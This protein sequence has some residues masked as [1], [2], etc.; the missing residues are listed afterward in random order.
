MTD[1]EKRHKRKDLQLKLSTT[2]QQSGCTTWKSS[3]LVFDYLV[4]W[5]RIEASYDAIG[6]FADNDD[7]CS[8][9]LLTSVVNC[10]SRASFVSTDF[11]KQIK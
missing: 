8:K 3:P 1:V 10:N 7:S 2:V 4:P 11:H 6:F 9:T 5:H